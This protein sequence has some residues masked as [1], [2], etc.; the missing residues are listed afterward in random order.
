MRW[1]A[2]LVTS[3]ALVAAGCGGGSNESAAS[4]ETTTTETTTSESTDTSMTESTD[5]ADLSGVLNDEDCLALAGVGATFAQAVTG[6]S[7]EQAADELQELVSK[8]PDEIKPDVQ[9]I[10][11]WFTQYT[12]KLKDIGI[13][14]GQAPTAQQLQQLQAALSSAN[15]NQQELTAASQHIE[16]W[17]Q[18]NCTG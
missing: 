11:E 8:V 16:T 12:A 3:L 4:T 9:V 15:A 17:A 18:N 7:D 13:K 5:T 2:L 10:A 6:A 1:L 14:A